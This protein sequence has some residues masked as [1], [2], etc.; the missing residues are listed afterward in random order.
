FYDGNSLLFI[1]QDQKCIPCMDVEDFSRF[2][3]DN[4]LPT[5]SNLDCSK[6]I[7]SFWHR[8]SA[9]LQIHIFHI[10]T[11]SIPKWCSSVNVS[12]NTGRALCISLCS[13]RVF[14]RLA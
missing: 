1:S 7:F 10:D 4:D 14:G 13:R 12:A 11:K 8:H 6:N 3:G 2:L 9:S 5:F